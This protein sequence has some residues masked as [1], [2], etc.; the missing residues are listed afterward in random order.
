MA[1]YTKKIKIL[2]GIIKR[3]IRII[4]SCEISGQTKIGKGFILMHKGIGVVINKDS[5]I[6]DYV[7][8]AQGCTIGGKSGENPPQLL[9]NVFIGPGA[10]VLGNVKVGPN[11]IVGSN[12]V[13][14]K[15]VPP[16]TIVGGIPAKKI[17]EINCENYEQY[18]DYF[19]N[20][21]I[22]EILL[23]QK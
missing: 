12:A 20:P 16:F 7:T 5:K 14:V 17:G 8:I 11:S 2:P 23:N 1:F 6:G 13:V 4:Y 3:L 18:K 9:N 10:K 21:N 15:D 22:K 19:S